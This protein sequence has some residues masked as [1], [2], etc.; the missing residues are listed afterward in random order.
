MLTPET[1]EKLEKHVVT[2]SRTHT[3]HF[4]LTSKATMLT[5]LHVSL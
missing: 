4:V 3:L 1:P 5:I 2:H